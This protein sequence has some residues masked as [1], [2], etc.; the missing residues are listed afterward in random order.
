MNRRV[1]IRTI[2]ALGFI[3]LAGLFAA[4]ISPLSWHSPAAVEANA[5]PEFDSASIPRTVDENT[6][7]FHDIGDPV[8][9]TDPNKDRLVYSLENASK[10]PFTIVRATG[11]L[12][13]GQ[14]LDYETRSTYTVT[15]QVTDMKDANGDPDDATDHTITVTITVNDVEENGKVSLTWTKPQV[16]TA[17]TA[18][19][20][21]PDGVTPDPTWEWATSNSRNGTYT[22][23]SGHGANTAIYTPQQPGDVGKYLQATASYTDGEGPSKTAQA[24][25]ATPVRAGPTD[26]KA[27][28]FKPEPHSYVCSN[29]EGGDVCLYIPRSSPAG[30]DIYYPVRAADP[31][32]DEIRYSLGSTTDDHLFSIDPVR[33]TLFTTE[34]HAY[35]NP[36]TDGKFEITITATDPSGGSDSINVVLKPSGSTGAPVVKGPERIQYSENGTWPVAT[37]SATVSNLDRDIREIH[38]WIISVQPGGGD[39]DFFDIDDD[40][41][42]TFTQP[43]DYEDPADENGDNVY[44]FHLHVWDPNPPDGGRPAQTFFPV[45][46]TVVDVEVE[47]LEIRGPSAVEYSENRTDPVATYWLESGSGSVEWFLSGADAEALSLSQG[48]E[49]TFDIPPDYE[50]PTDVAEENAYLVTITADRGGASKTEFIRVKVTNVNE[51]PEF[52]EGETATRSVGRDAEVNHLIG[53]P[54]AAT[55]PD[56]DGS[57]TY[58]LPDAQTLPFSISEYTGQ[59][60]LSGTLLQDR[61]SYTVAVLVTDGQNAAGNPDTSEDDRITVTINVEGDGNSAPG[62]PSTETVARS[63][64]ENS[65]GGQNVGGPVA[66]TDG[67]NDR[68]IYTLG[69]TD[70]ADFQILGTTGQIQTQAGVTYD[71]EDKSTYLVRV[72]AN[73]GNGGT[74]TQEVTI[75]VDNVEEPGTVTLSTNQPSA[76]TAITASLTDLDGG[77]TGTTWQWQK[78]STVQGAY[79]NING[80]TSDTYTPADE[81]VGDYLR[82]TASYTDGHDSGK[83]AQATTTQAVRAGENRPPEFSAASDNRSFAENTAAGENIGPPVTATDGDN[84]RLIY[85]LGGTDAADFQILGTTGQ[86]QTKAGE[87]Y[88]HETTPSYSV[89]VKADDSNGGTDTIDVSITVNNIDEPP[90]FK[91]GP[92]TV[93]F[94]ENGEGGVASYYAE[95][96]EY[97]TIHWTLEG[98]D[99]T[100]L[101]IDENGYLTF[102]SPPNFEVKGSDDRD[103]DYQVTV[104]ATS[105]AKTTTLNVTVTVTDVNEAPAF[106]GSETGARSVVENTAANQNIGTPVSADDPDKDADLTYSFGGGTDDSSFDLDTSTGHLKT[107]DA[108]DKETKYTYYVTISVTDGLDDSGNADTAEDD[109][110]DVT[111]TVTGEN[112]APEITSGPTA[113]T[114]YAENDTSDVGTYT[115]TDQENATINWSLDGDDDG[116][117]DISSAGVL[118]F[119]SAPNF[120]SPVDADTNNVYLVTV[121]AS[122]GGKTD[123]RP[124]TV[125]VTNVNEPPA[126]PSSETRAR[127]VVENTPANQNIGAPVAASDPDA[128]ASLTYSLAGTD[129][130]AFNFDTSTGQIK[131]NLPLDKETKETYSVDVSVTDGLDNSGN[132]DTATDNTI[133]VTITV[134]GENDAPTI[135]SGP[136]TLDHEENDSGDVATYTASDPEGTTIIWSLAGDDASFFGISGGTLAFDDVPNFEVEADHD[137]DNAYEVTVVASDGGKS[138][139]QPVTVTVTDVNEPPA[140]TAETDTREVA[141]NTTAGQPIGS[142]VSATDPDAGAALTYTLGGTDATSFD[143]V[144]TSGQLQTKGALDADT[145]DTYTVTVSVSDGLDENDNVDTSADDT[146]TVTITVTDQNEPPEITGGFLSVDY[147]ENGNGPAQTYVATDPDSSSL[148]WTLSGDDAGQF[149]ISGGVLT[150]K[151]P[152]NFEV[153][154]DANTDNDYEVTV[155]VSDGPNSDTLD[156]TVTVTDVNEPP[157]FP[158]T[159][160]GRRSVVENTASGQDIGDP[161]AAADPEG[162]DL[163]YSLRSTD[164]DAASFA[165]VATTGQLQTKD[166]LDS[167]TKGLYSFTI[168]IRDSKDASG[169]PDTA[170]DATI[171]VEITVTGVNEPPVISGDSSPDHP[172]NDAGVVA[173]YDDNDPEEA[174]ITWTLS[175]D[176]VGN[177]SINSDGELK[178][179]AAPDY[180]T[181]AD[182][183]QNNVY[184]VTLTASDGTHTDTFNV[185]VTVTNVNEAPTFP[186]PTETLTI[187]ENT[188]AA[189][190]IGIPVMARDPDTDVA[191]ATLTYTL[192]GTS[193]EA[194]FDIVGSSGQLQTKDDLDYESKASYSV[195]VSVTDGK[196]ADGNVN[197]AVDASVTVTI[198]V[199][200]MNDA[201]VITGPISPTY[202]ENATSEVATYAAT[203]Q[204]SGDTVT[205]RLSG[206][207]DASLSLSASGVLTFNSPPDFEDPTDVGKDG[208]YLV[209]IEAFDQTAT[210]TRPVTITIANVEEPGAVTFDSLQPQ[211]STVLTAEI[212][213]PDGGVSGDTWQWKE[214]E[215]PIT[216]WVDKT[217]ATQQAYTPVEADVG[218][219]LRATAS[220]TDAEGP[221]KSAQGLVTAVRAAPLQNAAPV[222]ADDTATRTVPENSVVGTNVGAPVTATD[223]NIDDTLTYSVEGTDTDSFSINQSTGQLRTEA[224][225]DEETKNTYSVTVKA[226]DPSGESDTIAVTITVTDQN[227]GPSVARTGLVSYPENGTVDIAEYTAEDPEGVTIIWSVTGTDSARFSVDASVVGSNSVAV[228]TFKTVPDFEAPADSDGNN[229]Y[230]VTVVASDGTNSNST[231]VIVTVT[232]VNE[233]PEF[234]STETGARSVAENTPA[235]QDIGLPVAAD[236]PDTD[237]TL[238]YTLGGTDAASFDIVASSGQLQTKA[239]LD[240]ESTASYSV[241]VSVRDS[242]DNSGNADT[243]TDNTIAVTITVTNLDDPPEITGGPARVSYA[244][245]GTG[246]VATYTATDPEKESITWSLAGSDDSFFSITDGVLKFLNPPNFEVKKDANTDNAYQVTVQ[247]SDGGKTGTRAVTVTVTGVNEPPAF[248]AET[249]TREVA[250][251][252]ATGQPIG[253]PVSATDPDAG[254]TLTYTLGGTDATSFDIV[255]TSGQ[256]QTKGALDADTKDTYTVTVSVSDGFDE[257]DN[258]DTSAD[259]T[260]TVTITATGENDAPTITSGPTVVTDYAENDTRDVATYAASD[261]EQT[262]IIWSVEGDDE[263]FFDITGGVLTFL[264]PPNFE[265]EGQEA[266]ADED[267]NYEVTVVAS[268]G[269]KTGTRAVTVTVTDV[270]ESPEFPAATDTRS[271]QE[272]TVS[273]QNIG[274][275]VEAADPDVDADPTYGFGG[276]ADDSSF[277]IDTS[278]GQLKTKVALDKETDDSYTVIVSVTDGKDDSGNTE[279]PAVVDDTVTVTITVTDQNEPP[280]ITGGLLS[281]DYAENSNGP[282]QTYVATDPDSSSLTWTLSG[283]DAGQFDI[284]GGVLTFKSPPNFEVKKDANSDNAYEVTV[285]V[286]DGEHTATRAVTVTVTN[287][288]DKPSFPAGE[289]GARSVEEGTEAG[290]DIGSPV[291]ATDADGD[292]LTYSVTGPDAAA[293]TFDTST[294]QLTTDDALDADTKAT[295]SF[296]IG[297]SDSKDASGSADNV[298]DNT[299]NVTIT[300]I[301]GPP[302]ISGD[303][304]PVHPENDTSAVGTYAGNAPQDVTIDWTLSGDDRGDFLFTSGELTFK[305]TPDFETPVDQDRNNIY[306]VTLEA[307]Y[308]TS[309]DTFDV[310]VTVTNKNEPPAFPATTDTRSVPENTAPGQNIGLPVMARDPDV[311]AASGTLTYTLGGTD[312]ASF[313]F[314]TSTGQLKTSAALDHEVRGSYTV[315]V[316]VT[317]GKD[318]AGNADTAADD[319]VTVTISV[320]GANDPPVITG[321][322][323]ITYAENGTGNVA[324]YTATDQDSGDTVRWRLSGPDG[325]GVD[326]HGLSI[327]STGVLTFISPPNFEE[328]KD[329]ADANGD[330]A[331]DN[332][333]LVTVE[334]FDG[335]VITTQDVTITVSNVD[336]AGE[337]TFLALQ[338]QVG[339]E[340]TAKI[341]D[342]DGSVTPTTWKWEISDDGSSGWST[343]A[344]ETSES[345]TPVATDVDKYLRVTLTYTDALP[346][347]KTLTARNANAV[348]AAP[349]TNTAPEFAGETTTRSVGEN[350]PVGTNVGAP[351]TATDPQTDTLTYFLVDSDVETSD[352]AS[353]TISQASGQLRTNAVLDRETK[354]LYT[355]TVKA[356]DPSGLDDTITVTI[357]VTDQNEAPVVART[358]RISYAENSTVDIV[359]YTARDPEGLTII[360]SPTGPD[361]ARFEIDAEVVDENSV[362]ALKFKTVPD[363]EAPTDSGSNNVYLVTVVASDGTY[364]NATDVIV[365]VT[366]VNERPAFPSTEN[367]QRT[368]REDTGTGQDIG[369]PVA[370]VDLD[371]GDS[372]TYTLGGADAASFGIVEATGQLQTKVALEYDTQSRYTVS[373][374]ATDTADNSVTIAV[375]I[376]V[377]EVVEAPAPPPPPPPQQ[378][379]VQPPPVQQTPTTKPTIDSVTP[380]NRSLTV[381]WSAPGDADGQTIT[382]YDMRHIKSS[383]ANPA[384]SDWIATEDVWTGAGDLVYDLIGLDNDAEYNVQVRAGYLV[385][386]GPWSD[387]ETGT[388]TA[389]TESDDGCRLTLGSPSG[390]VTQTGTWTSDC[391]S[392]NRIGSYA[393]FYTFTLKQETDLQIDL[394]SSQDTYLFLLDGA[395]T[396]GTVEDS[397]DD[398]VVNEDVNS[399][400]STTLAAGAYTIE[401]TTYTPRITGDFTLTIT[402]AGGGGSSVTPPGGTQPP[403]Q[404]TPPGGAQPPGATPPGGQ[405]PPAQVGPADAPTITSVTPGTETLTVAWD[406][407]SNTGSSEITA[408]DLRHIRSSVTERAD[409]HWIVLEDVWSDS[410]ALEYQLTGLTDNIGY[411]IQVRASYAIGS[412]SWSLTASGTPGTTGSPGTGTPTGDACHVNLKTLTTNVELTGTWVSDCESVNREGRYARFYSFTLGQAGQVQI[413]LTSTQDPYLFLLEG[414]TTDGKVVVENDDVV[415]NENTNSRIVTTL[416]AG[417]HTIEATTYHTA[418]TGEFSLTISLP[419]GSGGSGGSP[420][421]SSGPGTPSED[422][423]EVDLNVLTSRVSREGY[424]AFD[425]DSTN[426]AGRYARYYTFTLRQEAELQID[427]VS[428]ED[429]F[430]FLLEGA[431]K[432]GEVLAKNDDVAAGTDLNSRIS[433]T[434]AAGRYTIEATTYSEEV[435]GE[436]TLTIAFTE[437]V[438]DIPDPCVT[439]LETPTGVVTQTGTWADDCQSTNR[440]GTYARFYSFTLEQEAELQIDLMS[441]HDPFLFLLHG[442]GRDGTLVA[443]NDDVTVSVDL[444]SRISM[445]LA[446]GTYTIEA[447]TYNTWATGDFTLRIVGPEGTSAQTTDVCVEDLGTPSNV[448]TKTGT[449]T[450]ACDS[451]SREGQYARFYTFTLEQQSEVQIDLV[452]TQDPYLFLLQ[453]TGTNGAEVASNDDIVPNVEL[454]SLISVTLAAGSYTIEATTYDVGETGAFTLTLTP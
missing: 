259:D 381:A 447:T 33:G 76:R 213:D 376:V 421:G 265:A 368:V 245:N 396:D 358:D 19:L 364:S 210:T 269:A 431:G 179:G 1:L 133:T 119:K 351:V 418:Q 62:F 54:V 324:T 307:D 148:T 309:T 424:W 120:E 185:T 66:A 17:I 413:D 159:E 294:G 352:A 281:V 363:F 251:N 374:T 443:Q 37:Y 345:Y 319:T 263:E 304:S 272:N 242:K 128:G 397:N 187:P 6:P 287:V 335:T 378:R 331:K 205:W 182:D 3:A 126:F 82:A 200:D 129:A 103:N 79:S 266:D 261:P 177:F 186:E 291:A 390:T 387:S 224:V 350:A 57:L 370:A 80:A 430:A 56:E 417:S 48:G 288:N 218:K 442:D 439:P 344:N 7:P 385:D 109:Y 199:T 175:G 392:V 41:V 195:T 275:P 311:D 113:V 135:T 50:N 408:Y 207:D 204:D 23:L 451:T 14:P 446:A 81:D 11:Q 271:V 146:I 336:E 211:V 282:A 260:I 232:N 58:T 90:V 231:D 52:D 55:D 255:A 49:L 107:R 419:Q 298:V 235:G 252:T 339:T 222:F 94:P 219:Y 70:A 96:P 321:S 393:L 285:Q 400:I 236:D 154:K 244:E 389:G 366:D 369:S 183:G 59:L 284:S 63:F 411:D 226:T 347:S 143:I 394:T 26:N 306:L 340:L 216:G 241:T 25:S 184:L 189:Q 406:A 114:D 71:Y 170:T 181:P 399:R 67:D 227:E 300:V 89:T 243:A 318:A 149:D 168:E 176:D 414:G 196:D 316:S 15:V 423:C 398:V 122:D 427:V 388:P 356:T 268:D 173:T 373:V 279:D 325:S 346:A 257:N 357:S 453:G 314:D 29:G 140:F 197:P 403:A 166:T 382:S 172:E 13:V 4:P 201:P 437:A 93:E 139:T 384:D 99:K 157:T 47:A 75:T 153:E 296:T 322:D 277:T 131:T 250:E 422:G 237:A 8:T 91:E 313:G 330:G 110:I 44:N 258:P 333:Y 391:D 34:A 228:L 60:S 160:D 278:T 212:E 97:A 98:D 32:G 434:L 151:S 31:A 303:A 209:V 323:S 124:V 5:P 377:T 229:V 163:T 290:E 239:D 420:P 84:D 254:A 448:V 297:V 180:E 327:S 428:T 51:P 372:L 85:T 371:A 276:G 267:D 40:G 12:Q 426:R 273:D 164:A 249:D 338:P 45:R 349:I 383:V 233:R 230:L 380:E 332:V 274:L 208:E 190:N 438:E 412:G 2:V 225:L 125:T 150:F 407:P 223:S 69:G 334:A 77:V 379:P 101:S 130:S 262:T 16:N 192:G 188:V 202:D 92:T 78:S 416:A 329:K 28:A 444:N 361:S 365:T 375:A 73:D 401:A 18:S 83:S 42:L 215:N 68:L 203:D 415:V 72:T 169:T 301:A 10:S 256:L 86:I 142:P 450:D 100:L 174:G 36:G 353:F 312:A 270:N 280:E 156:V 162:D 112:D 429:P 293:F 106:P 404:G 127:S 299:I 354:A 445:T 111:I 193:D 24:V 191:F 343:I 144:A 158:S 326:S 9:A 20:T 38:G 108:L 214:F 452:S 395:G 337:L 115:A 320:T 302:E 341:V 315:T 240:L 123:T 283:D 178:F 253:S 141:E 95:D 46:V 65:T 386:A 425:C 220:Y 362:A 121:V 138:D 405:Q 145:K 61:S 348:R 402:V 22:N 217:G 39:G 410:G 435:A 102:D 286:S 247:A 310:T 161:V 134:T 116:D 21:D 433:A 454:D 432:D 436:F 359:E 367:G 234:P 441:S 171:A 137:G 198:T 167:D 221:G 30:D 147:S 35:D 238:T 246:D 295:Y 87:T 43:P 317:D 305:N 165:I 117:F 342:P 136:A 105:G 248:T 308:G 88:D 409:S 155:R 152:P 104:Q 64:P 449:W 440:I 289:T 360:W 74:D 292:T 27:P 264:S 132:P 355:V 206:A 53:E 118:T 328:A 194:S